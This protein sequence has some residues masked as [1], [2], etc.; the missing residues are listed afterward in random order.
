MRIS[1]REYQK[2]KGNNRNIKKRKERW[3]GLEK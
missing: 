1:K 3:N 2:E